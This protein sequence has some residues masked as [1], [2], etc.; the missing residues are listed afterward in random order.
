MRMQVDVVA[1]GI[2]AKVALAAARPAVQVAVVE[3]AL[4]VE[5]NNS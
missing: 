4:V 3:V 2:V 5:V 1:L